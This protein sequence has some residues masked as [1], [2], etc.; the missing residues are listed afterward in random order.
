MKSYSTFHSWCPPTQEQVGAEDEPISDLQRG[1]TRKEETWKN[2]PVQKL[3][4][5]YMKERTVF[6]LGKKTKKSFPKR[7]EGGI[8]ESLSADQ[9]VPL[10][11]ALGQLHHLPCINVHISTMFIFY[12]LLT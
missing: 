1:A 5:M 3:F 4:H 8:G 12:F 6:V 10:D 2:Q 11:P 9:C 7:P